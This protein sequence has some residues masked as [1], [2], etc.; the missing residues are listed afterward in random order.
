MPLEAGAVEAPGAGVP[1]ETAS[2]PELPLRGG[3]VG[4]AVDV[5]GALDVVAL[6]DVSAGA[7]VLGAAGVE[8]PGGPGPVVP[9]GVER[10]DAAPQ[11]SSVEPAAASSHRRRCR[12]LGRGIA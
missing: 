7:G 8:L 6:E 11:P 12:F 4:A 5:T 3:A 1:P 9:A 10:V 2:P